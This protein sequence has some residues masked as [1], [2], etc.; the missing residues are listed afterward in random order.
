ML[1][2]PKAPQLQL[3]LLRDCLRDRASGRGIS[4]GFEAPHQRLERYLFA[5]TLRL[6]LGAVTLGDLLLNISVDWLIGTLLIVVDQFDVVFKGNLRN[7]RTFPKVIRIE[8]GG[9]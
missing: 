4:A 2:S 8:C 1:R 3:A 5:E 7:A 6:K 9:A